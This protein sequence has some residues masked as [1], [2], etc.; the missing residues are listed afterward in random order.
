MA[1]KQHK[2]HNCMRRLTHLDLP[3]LALCHRLYMMVLKKIKEKETYFLTSY[4]KLRLNGFGTSVASAI[5]I[6][7]GESRLKK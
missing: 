7:A 1:K 4:Q 6:S 3:L 2:S 5:F